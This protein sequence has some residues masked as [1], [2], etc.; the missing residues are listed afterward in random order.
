MNEAITA[1]AV[2]IVASLRADDA[3]RAG[4][5]SLAALRQALAYRPDRRV[6]RIKLRYA[7]PDPREALREQVPDS[8]EVAEILASLDRLDRASAAGPWTRVTLEIIDR[9]P[10]V[11]APVLATELGRETPEFKR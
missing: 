5:P 2:S 9:S 7:G 4:A 3:R 1:L 11:R 8:A 10:G 6:H